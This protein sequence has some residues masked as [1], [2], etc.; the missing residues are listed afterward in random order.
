[1]PLTLVVIDP[2]HW[3]NSVGRVETTGARH[4]RG[5]PVASRGSARPQARPLAD[6]LARRGRGRGGPSN[7]LRYGL[8]VPGQ[9]FADSQ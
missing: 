3:I 8:P 4:D 2:S 5:G 1:M 6:L 7:S 9:E